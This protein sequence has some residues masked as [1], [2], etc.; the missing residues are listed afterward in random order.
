VCCGKR[1]RVQT[2]ATIPHASSK[3]WGTY[4]LSLCFFAHSFNGI[5]FR[6]SFSDRFNRV[7]ISSN[8]VGVTGMTPPLGLPQFELLLIRKLCTS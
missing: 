5:E 7:T 8:E 6:H 3:S 1:L 2:F 4:L